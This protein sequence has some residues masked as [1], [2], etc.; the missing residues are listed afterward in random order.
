MKVLVTGSGGFLGRAVVRAVAQAGHEVLALKRPS[1]PSGDRPIEATFP[2]QVTVVEGDL[3]Q[4]GDW[5]APVSEAEAVIHCAA[6]ASG[7]LPHQLS[8]TVLA[9]E[10]LLASLGV[11]LRRFV[12]VSTFSVYDFAGSGWAKTLDEATEIEPYPL[13]RDFYTQTKLQQE[14]LVCDWSARQAVPLVVARPGAIYGPGKD[15]GFGA[16]FRVGRFDLLFAPLSRMR[17]I[18]VD[19]C[20]QALVSALTYPSASRIFVNLVDS[21]QPTHWGFH[22]FARQAGANVGI[23]LPVPYFVLR[24]LGTLASLTSAAFFSGRARLPEWL[25]TYRMRARWG[26]F[27]YDNQRANEICSCARISLTQ[28]LQKMIDEQREATVANSAFD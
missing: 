23:G 20:A 2:G 4:L 13:K 6:T 9:T 1:S 8:G 17:L 18:Y 26:Q 28:G 22:R 10:N 16:A 3:R 19:N 7:D 25:D 12:H 11:N 5:V 21:E 15:W 24:G 27:H 14:R